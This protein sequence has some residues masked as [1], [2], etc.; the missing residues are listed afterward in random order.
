MITLKSKNE[1]NVASFA[2]STAAEID[3][4]PT[5][6]A[7]GTGAGAAFGAVSAGSTAL[8]TSGTLKIFMLDGDTNEWKER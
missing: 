1:Y 4:L 8:T 6:T 2:I 3:Y 7:A 5:T